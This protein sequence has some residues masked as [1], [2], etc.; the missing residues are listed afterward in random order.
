MAKNYI[1][2]E[3][4][5]TLVETLMTLTVIGVIAA[6]T[7]PTLIENIQLQEAKKA[8]KNNYS[9]MAAAYTKAL[10]AAGTS[11]LLDIPGYD[12]T[13]GI[14]NIF[15][16]QLSTTKNCDSNSYGEGCW[17]YQVTNL[18]TPVTSGRGGS[19]AGSN[20]TSP[21]F[22]LNNGAFVYVSNVGVTNYSS[23]IRYYAIIF[24]DVNGDEAPNQPGKD[25]FGFVV[26]ENSI[27]PYP[28]G[29][30]D[31]YGN[32]CNPDSTDVRLKLACSSDY[33]YED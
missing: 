33:L 30:T 5:F 28:Y 22:T 27:K 21:G 14:K 12:S 1:A 3:K 7:I 19:P 31:G 32:A 23:S 29:S 25:L 9:L 11:S 16:G 4:G 17:T 18:Q 6:L 13:L 24:V 15:A 8:W 26:L 2:T 10:T 20:T